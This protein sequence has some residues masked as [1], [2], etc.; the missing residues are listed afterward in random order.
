MRALVKTAGRAVLADLPEPQLDRPDDVRLRVKVGGLCRTDLAVLEGRIATK[1]PL[2]VGHEVAAEVHSFGPAVHDLR[3]GQPVAIAPW[4]GCGACAA[5][6]K[7]RADL[8]P[9]AEMLGLHRDGAFCETLVLPRSA[10][11]PLPER[12]SWC[13]RAFVEPVAACLGV[14]NAPLPREGRGAILGE[15]RIAR[16]TQ[17][18]MAAEGFRHVAV[19]AP[20]DAEALP[21]RGLD[22]AV[23]TT[24]TEEGLERVMRALRPGGV[25]VLKSRPPAPVRI[26][27]WLAVRKELELR[28]VHYGSFA[29]AIELLASRRLQVHDLFGTSWPLAGFED[30]LAAAAEDATTKQFL[31]LDAAAAV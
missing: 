18:V 30:A 27:A 24:G 2:I 5:C 15:D 8:C 12:L 6:R 25:L 21:E 29:H 28:G 3:A 1:E 14:L 4:L 9:E 10:L 22:F 19:A 16:L 26:D 20:D 17:R 11:H 23:E 13:E 7:E 31:V